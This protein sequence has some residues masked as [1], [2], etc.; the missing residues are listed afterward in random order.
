[1]LDVLLVRIQPTDLLSKQRPKDYESF[2]NNEPLD[3]EVSVSNGD[4]LQFT[5]SKEYYA[6]SD[7]FC[8]KNNSIKEKLEVS[9]AGYVVG[10]DRYPVSQFRKGVRID[11]RRNSGICRYEVKCCSTDFAYDLVVLL[12][13]NQEPIILADLNFAYGG[14]SPK[15]YCSSFILFEKNA[16]LSIKSPFGEVIGIALKHCNESA[17]EPDSRTLEYTMSFEKISLPAV[18]LQ[19]LLESKPQLESEPQE[20]TNE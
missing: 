6:G 16:V 4:S 15:G 3:F 14:A 5:V 17:L 8:E 10:I 12:I 2:P 19:K 9:C 1:M 7:A 13:P 18:I 11:E 20:E